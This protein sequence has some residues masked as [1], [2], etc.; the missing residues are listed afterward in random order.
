LRRVGAT[1]TLKDMT[2]LTKM[3][4]IFERAPVMVA[5]SACLYFQSHLSRI[6]VQAL[7]A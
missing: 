7:Q 2:A 4:A 5:L 1:L 3:V 6:W